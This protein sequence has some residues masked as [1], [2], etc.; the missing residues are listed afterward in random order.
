MIKL[1]GLESVLKEHRWKEVL[2]NSTPLSENMVGIGMEP[3][4]KQRPLI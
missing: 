4:Q 3:V 2:L 1:D